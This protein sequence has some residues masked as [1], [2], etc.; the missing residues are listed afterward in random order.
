M[1]RIK[2]FIIASA[3]LFGSVIFKRKQRVVLNISWRE[4]NVFVHFLDLIFDVR[5]KP[6]GKIELRLRQR[7]KANYERGL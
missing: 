1:R 4:H 2:A 5:R 6:C 7:R 3:S